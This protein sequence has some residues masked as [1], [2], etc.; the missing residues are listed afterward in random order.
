MNGQ[1]TGLEEAGWSAFAAAWWERF[2]DEEV[3]LDDLLT[4]ALEDGGLGLGKRWKRSR[5]EQFAH[6]LSQRSTS[7]I[8]GYRVTPNRVVRGVQKWRLLLV[9]P[10]PTV[11]V[12]SADW[13]VV[14]DGFVCP[15]GG[16]FRMDLQTGVN[17]GRWPGLTEVAT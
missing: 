13:Q 8:D 1:S 4:V 7:V 12:P 14:P 17:L 15:P 2:H 16:E 6:L 11:L 3:S 10:K 5:R 9:K